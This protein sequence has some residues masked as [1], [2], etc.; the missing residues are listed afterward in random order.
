M[1]HC[2]HC[3]H[4]LAP[5]VRFCPGCGQAVVRADETVVNAPAEGAT[6]PIVPAPASVAPAPAPVAAA[7]VTP[8][9]ALV[10]PAP[11]PA[12]VAAA[13]AAPVAPAAPSAPAV[14]MQSV[15]VNV[16]VQ[17]PSAPAMPNVVVVNQASGP[18]CLVRGIYFLLI[19][20]WLGLFWTSAAWFLMVTVI[21]LPFGLMMLNRLPQVMTLKPAAQQTNV[22]MQNGVLLIQQG[23]AAQLPF[24]M[25]ALYFVAVGWWLSGLWLGVAWGLIGVSFGLGL[26][27]AFW[28]FDRTPAITTLAK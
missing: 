28:M 8:A 22:S 25:R 12:P 5:D 13:S 6:I 17:A 16:S 3:D 19:G 15:N 4:V 18:G 7:P 21:G 9:P 14:P 10:A 27:L 24:W 2:T 11:A 20:L 1:Q 26:P 23:R